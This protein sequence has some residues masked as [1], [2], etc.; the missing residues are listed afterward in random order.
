MSNEHAPR[1]I[2]RAHSGLYECV[3]RAFDLVAGCILLLFFSPLLL[4]IA[5]LVRRSSPGPVFFRQVRVGRLDRP[6]LIYKFRTMFT[7][8]DQNG[9]QITATDDERITP[10]GRILR[11]TKLDELPQLIN[12]VKGDMSLVGPRPQVPRFVDEFPLDDR[13]IVLAVRPGITGPTQLKFRHEEVMLE[14]VEDREQYYIEN[15]LPLK[16]R[17]DVEYVQNR[18]AV[19]DAV[20]L[21]ETTALFTRGTFRRLCRRSHTS[22]DSSLLDPLRGEK[23]D[24]LQEKADVMT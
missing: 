22:I 3:K 12:V 20:I 4:L 2:H 11:N 15:L 6:F 7:D 21:L 14:G 1:P 5:F 19:Y 17:M 18:S 24:K 13:A 8:A 16:C 10:L 23:S 9:P